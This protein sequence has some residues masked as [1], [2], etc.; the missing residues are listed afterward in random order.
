MWTCRVKYR[1]CDS[2][3]EYTNFRD[4]LI[5]YKCLCCNKSYQH[6]FNEK[7]KQQFSNTIK[8]SNHD[9]NKFFL[10]LQKGVYPNEYMG[11]WD[12]FNKTSLTEKEGFYSHLNMDDITDADCTHGKKF[13][14]D[15]EI[16]YLGEY[17]DLYVQSDALSL[18]DVSENFRN[19]WVKICKR[20]HGKFFSAPGL[21]RQAGL[22]KTKVKL[23]LLIDID[24][25]SMVEKGKRGGICHSF[26][27]YAKVYD[28]YMNIHD[29][30]KES[31]YI[32]YWDVNNLHGWAI[33]QKL[34]VNNF[35][36][37]KDSQLEWRLNSQFNKDVIKKYNGES[38]EGYFL[39]F[40][41]QYPENLHN[42]HFTLKNEDWKSH[43]KTEY[44]IHKKIKAGIKSWIMD[45]FWKHYIE[46]LKLIKMLH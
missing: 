2:F 35:E 8:D 15:F 32:Q 33:S 11:N 36:W 31:S 27:R 4:D 19:M 28:K 29:K 34:L 37:I 44:V 20:D 12:K 18:A 24:L 43:D 41:V 21:T 13:C 30:N 7:L 5:K 45:Y 6:K 14:K 23:D 3:L 46:L 42:L 1:Y 40:D 38:H 10:L 22:K 16:K 25:L 17:H 9:K 39:E 26:Y